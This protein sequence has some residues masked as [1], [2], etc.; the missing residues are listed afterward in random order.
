M[1]FLRPFN[2][3]TTNISY[4]HISDQSTPRF[5]GS[6]P[7]HCLVSNGCQ[8]G[9]TGTSATPTPTPTGTAP[10]TDGRCGKDFG[11]ATCDANGPYGGCCSEYGHVVDVAEH[12]VN[13]LL[14]IIAYRFCGSTPA[15]CLKANG[16]QNGCT[17]GN[18]GPATTTSQEPVIGPVSTTMAPG[19]TA[20]AAVTT[21]GTCGSSNG[22][23]VCG[24]WPNGNCCSMYGFW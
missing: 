8:N 16:C 1:T 3:P 19:T 6:T 10:R 21:D 2:F 20:T 7:D 13:R 4:I 11:G 18:S 9:C 22:N 23:T 12:W 15:H 5:C 17:D 24:N 14:T